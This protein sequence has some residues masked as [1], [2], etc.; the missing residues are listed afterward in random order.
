MKYEHELAM[1]KAKHEQSD[2]SI[3]AMNVFSKVPKLPIFQDEN[4]NID[5]YLERF[6][7][8]AKMQNWD[9]VDYA[10]ILS[11]LLTG[12]ALEVYSR[13]PINDASDYNKIK[14]ALLKS[15]NCSEEGFRRMFRK[16]KPVDSESPEQYAT[17]IESYCEKWIEM[18]GVSTYD[19]LKNLIVR[20][21]FLNM[22]PQHLATHLNERAF[23]SIPEMCL[24]AERYLQA[25]NQDMTTHNQARVPGYKR[26]DVKIEN[27][28]LKECY[29]CG[30]LGHTRAKCRNEGGGDEQKCSRCNMFGHS[31]EVCRNIKERALMMTSRETDRQRYETRKQPDNDNTRMRYRK[32]AMNIKDGLLPV[33][34]MINNHVADTLRDTGCTTVCVNKK[35]VL[36]EQLTGCYKP[37]TLMDGSER[38]LETALVNLDTPYIKRS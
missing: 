34:G 13:M 38:L 5:A 29:N 17:R 25:H 15:Y 9:T 27:T 33:K 37:C 18:A 2:K 21:Q 1:Q 14:A 30:K 16:A 22:C 32:K 35:L 4:D 26:E 19:E 7:R 6:E 3:D 10:M 36:P 23:N 12:K 31:E 11:A 28:E 24:Q 8:S 20:E